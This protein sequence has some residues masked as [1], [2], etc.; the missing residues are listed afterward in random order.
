LNF[1]YERGLVDGRAF[2]SP[3]GA[4]SSLAITKSG[5][6]T[7]LNGWLYW[8]VRR[9]GKDADWVPLKELQPKLEAYELSDF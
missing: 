2:D 4:A 5:K 1:A 7:S 8:K 6:T 3:S 9:I